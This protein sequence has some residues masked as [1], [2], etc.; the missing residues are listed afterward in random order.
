MSESIL[1]VEDDLIVCTNLEVILTELGYSIAGFADNGV[2]ALVAFTT[3]RPA[4]VICD[5]GLKG[6]TD[7]IDLVHKMN[8]IRK[9]PVIF[10]TAH[11]EESV[12]QKARTA[13]PFAFISKPIDRKQISRS[14][15]LAMEHMEETLF[16]TDPAPTGSCLY[17]RVGNKLKKIMIEDIEFAE[18]DGKYSTIMVGQRQFNCKIS[19]KDLADKLP[20]DRFVQINRNSLINLEKIEDIDLGNHSV[21]MP[22]K[23]IP[24]SRI[25]KDQLL[26][27]INII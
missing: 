18:V 23:E 12:F 24:I 8:E 3:K 20:A 14:V 6:S 13:G 26:H 19:L 4:L 9:V 10:L 21:K 15:A 22:S 27:K 5:I 11:E 16:T 17:T 2:D 7:G 25:F 1:I